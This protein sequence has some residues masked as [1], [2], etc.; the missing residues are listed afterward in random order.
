MTVFV[1]DS[2]EN[3]VTT[4]TVDEVVGAILLLLEGHFNV[5]RISLFQRIL[6]RALLLTIK[7]SLELLPC[8]LVELV[9]V[10]RE[11]AISLW[12]EEQYASATWSQGL[13]EEEGTTDYTQFITEVSIHSLSI[14]GTNKELSLH[15]C[16]VCGE[17]SVRLCS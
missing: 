9:T 12:R 15:G 1:R 6:S 10:L 4:A 3:S 5:K 2:T 16:V 11:K 7:S 8:Q 13:G 14:V 17:D